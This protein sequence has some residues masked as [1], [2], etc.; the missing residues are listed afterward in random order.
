MSCM[1]HHKTMM[2]KS[3]RSKERN[4]MGKQILINRPR[5]VWKSFSRA[6]F[7]RIRF[8]YACR[9]KVLLYWIK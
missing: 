5:S 7:I 8:V 9:I 1:N 4:L 2:H 6:K 3:E